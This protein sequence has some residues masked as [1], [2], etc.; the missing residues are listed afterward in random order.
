[1]IEEDFEKV[2]L[3]ALYRE[4]ANCIPQQEDK[5]IKKILKQVKKQASKG[6][7]TLKIDIDQNGFNW[8]KYTS[9]RSNKIKPELISKLENY[10]FELGSPSLDTG[11]FGIYYSM[12]IS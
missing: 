9:L 3:A 1:M 2:D 6:K 10:G 5:D 7:F 12:I 8:L 11:F 4:I